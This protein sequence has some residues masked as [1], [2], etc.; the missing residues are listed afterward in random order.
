MAKFP[1]TLENCRKKGMRIAI[2]CK[3]NIPLPPLSPKSNMQAD[4]TVQLKT[5]SLGATAAD[6]GQTLSSAYLRVLN[7]GG[8]T[9]YLSKDLVVDAHTCQYPDYT[10]FIKNC[11]HG[12]YPPE[13]NTMFM[14][15]FH[16]STQYTIKSNSKFPQFISYN[17]NTK[18]ISPVTGPNSGADLTSG[19]SM[20]IFSKITEMIRTFMQ[21]ILGLLINL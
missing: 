19:F 18:K 15:I 10:W 6:M 17:K 14:E 4:G 7:N 20:E 21:R 2:V 13:I 1:Q 11:P 9:G 12:E 16:S 8:N 5:M 3:Y